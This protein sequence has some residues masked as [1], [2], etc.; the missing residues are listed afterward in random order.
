MHYRLKALAEAGVRLVLHAWYKEGHTPDPSHL[1]QWIDAVHF[2]PRKGPVRSWDIQMPYIM[3][4][5]ITGLLA[6]RLSQ[7]NAPVW[8][9]GIHTAGMLTKYPE[10]FTQ[11]QK[12]LRAHNIET[13]YYQELAGQA[14][15][16]LEKLYFRTE[17]RRLRKFEYDLFPAFDHIFSIS[18]TE[19]KEIQKYNP[20][21]SWLPAFVHYREQKI[22]R[23]PLIDLDDFR[24]LFHG[25]F[26]VTENLNTAKDLIRHVLPLEHASAH[27]VLAGKGL[28]EKD[29]DQTQVELHPDPVSMDAVMDTVDLVLLTGKQT[30]G[31]KI[32]L[33][34]SL[35][36]GKR[37]I[38]SPETLKG[39]GLE[40]KLPV[41]SS[42]TE[43]S[44]L[45]QQTRNQELE[46]KFLEG[47]Q[48]FRELYDPRA[49]VKAIIQVLG[50][51]PS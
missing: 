18:Q 38:A 41:I 50:N 10:V 39:S 4:S 29:F 5:R 40:G 20:A 34:E 6:S 28:S 11:R 23:L 42:Y 8:F 33:L 19:V 31:V 36:A 14:P 17:A 2:Y 35:A 44:H 9:D 48:T 49:G 46:H 27:L 22:T 51:K 12:F 15:W 3:A 24:V 30:S 45:L 16:G 37:V 13:A 47:I 26:C 7:D 43:L 1:L 25:N 21:V 32:K